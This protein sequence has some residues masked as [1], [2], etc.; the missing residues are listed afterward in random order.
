MTKFKIL[1]AISL[2]LFSCTALSSGI[3]VKKVSEHLHILSGKEY[4]TNIGLIPIN[5]GLVLIDPMP[6]NSHLSELDKIVRSIY[7]KPITFILNTHAHSDHAG[8][9]EYFI[10]QGGKLVGSTS[11]LVGFVHI[12]A[13]S[14][15]AID[16]IYYHTKSNAVFVGDVFDTSWHPTFYAGGTKGFIEAIDAIL[17]LGDD[18]TLIVPGHGAPSSKLSLREFRKNTL[19]WISKIRE[20]DQQG[21]DVDRIMDDAKVKDVLEKFNVNNEAVFL[22]QKAFRR[23]IERTIAV[24]KREKGM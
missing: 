4:G 11:N 3:N 10:Q 12:K 17:N 20:L 19:E 24:V 8:G 6:G 7:D 15:S 13:K 22:P 5:D 23:F 2:L 16:N 21:W 14:H 9:N 18:Q 1:I